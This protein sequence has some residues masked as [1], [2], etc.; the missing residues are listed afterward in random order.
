MNRYFVATSLLLLLLAGCS[1]K[2]EPLAPSQLPPDV[3]AGKAVAREVCSSC[4]GM[5]GRGVQDNIPNLAAQLEPYL[6][7]TIQTYNHGKRDGSG[8]GLMDITKNLTPA[9][10]R[11][12]LGYYASLP[13]LAGG[14]N[15]SHRYSYY[16]RG[17]ELSKSCASC[18]G[19]DGNPVRAGIPRLAGQHPQ[20]IVKATTAY[21]NGTRIMPAMHDKLAGLSRADVENMAV[22]FAL[23]KPRPANG[24][25]N[26][27][28][29]GMQFIKDCAQCHG[30]MGS[31]DSANIPNLAGQDVKYLDAAIKAYRD[32]VRDLGKVHQAI[33]GF[34]DSEVGKI[35]A[36]FAAESPAKVTFVLPEP[37][38]VLAQKCD[39]CHD[40]GGTNPEMLAPKLK[41]QHSTYLVNALAAYRDSD[42]G[43]S[44]MH[45]ISTV[46]N[47]DAA[48]E[49]TAY[50]YS[51]QAG[52]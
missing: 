44:A 26:K 25:M 4:H 35:A 36:F 47:F 50:Y 23:N 52:K 10:L 5:D 41:G 19:A 3:E 38:E 17:A 8:G 18:H 34:N 42:R 49:G 14:G 20:Y 46:F 21:Q 27:S 29:E 24:K 15:T 2:K 40:A 16:D 11:N 1:E 32:K 7:K 43:N 51:G 30:S 31:S 12:A 9:Q 39:I 28:N 6:L 45:R 37:V 48:I 22:Y 13:P 33:S